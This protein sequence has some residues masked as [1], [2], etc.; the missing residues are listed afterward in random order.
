MSRTVR[1]LLGA[2]AAIAVIACIALVAV[3]LIN[4]DGGEA[5]DPLAGTHWQVQSYYDA[6]SGGMA[7]PLADTQLTAEFTGGET[8]GE[9]VVGGSAGCNNYTAGYTVDGDALSVGEAAAT[10]MFCDGLMDQEGAFLAAM[11]SASSF[12]LE[13]EQLRILG[14]QG[15]AVVDLIPYTE[16]P[17]ATEPPPAAE[18]SWDRIEAAG[19]MVVGTAADYPPF[20]SYTGPG[21]IDG[22]DIALMD[23]IGRRLGIS[24][25]Y[26]DYAFDGLG[27]ALIQGEIDAAIAAISRTPEREATVDFS[28]VYLVA[29]DGVLA[30]EDA[31]ITI[32]SVDDLAAYKVGVQRNTV[33][34]EWIQST[35]VDTGRMPRPVKLGA[36]VRWPRETVE[37]WIAQACPK[38]EDMEVSR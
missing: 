8:A 18:D 11:Q 3:W 28:N 20:E 29:E 2:L 5:A 14:D 10:M 15:Q 23:D 4:R 22:F 12:E 13:T 35:L 30:Q 19:K 34:Q 16:M 7:S 36:L 38:A 26:R 27:P 37:T 21:Q 24:S 32:G 9:G 1:I 33:Y 17:E 6:A 31:D 25:D